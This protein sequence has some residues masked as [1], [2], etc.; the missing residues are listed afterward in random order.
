MHDKFFIIY[1][2]S[3]GYWNVDLG[4][5]SNVKTASLFV[6]ADIQT[7]VLPSNDSEWVAA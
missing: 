7:Q 3:N 1:S 5:G 2:P 6:L 4:W